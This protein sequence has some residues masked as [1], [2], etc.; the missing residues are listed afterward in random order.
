VL[1]GQTYNAEDDINHVR[2]LASAFEDKR[3]IRV[4]GKPLFLVYRSSLLPEPQATIERW[5]EESVRLGIGELFICRVESMPDENGDPRLIGFDAAVEFQP[6][7]YVL[8]FSAPRR[9]WWKRAIGKVS[10]EQAFDGDYI[11]DYL[12]FVRDMVN[13]PPTPYPRIPCV[14]PSWDNSARRRNGALIFVNSTPQTYENWLA[15]AVSKAES[16]E[17]DNRLVFINA[18]NEWA[19]GNHLEPCQKWGRAYLEATRKVLVNGRNG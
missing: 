2:Y 5:R 3:Y 1:L 16:I 4:N 7:W 11:F 17:G 10:K 14:F 6:R 9:A 8:D 19:E 18:W 15:S 12:Q 13:T